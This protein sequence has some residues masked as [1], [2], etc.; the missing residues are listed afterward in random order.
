MKDFIKVKCPICDKTH[1]VPKQ[2]KMW[3]RVFHECPYC[4]HRMGKTLTE[5]RKY[6]CEENR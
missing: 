1:H 5:L 4:E 6:N 3:M 2:K